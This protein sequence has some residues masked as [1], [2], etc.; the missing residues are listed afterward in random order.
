[1]TTT[2]ISAPFTLTRGDISLTTDKALLQIPVMHD[3][4]ANRSYWAK[5]IPIETVQKAAENSLTFALLHNGAQIGYARVVSDFAT[6]AYLGDVYVLPAFRGQGLS[7]WMMETIMA[8]PDL[9]GLRRWILLT[10]DAHGLYEQFGWTAVNNP[11]RYIEQWTQ[12]V[13][14]T[15][16]A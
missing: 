5:N 3:F 15:Q 11:A 14:S 8:H 9:Q 16:G 12:N 1:M 10:A 4:L 13:Y 6:V 2:P 7:K